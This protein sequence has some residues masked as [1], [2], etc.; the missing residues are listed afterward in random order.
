MRNHYVDL[1]Q[2]IPT[3]SGT[4]LGINNVRDLGDVVPYGNR[5]VQQGSP[6]ELATTFVRDSNINF[7]D[8]MAYAGTEYEKYKNK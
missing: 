3:L 4:V 7:F 1:A 8:A 5:I 2:N 6:L